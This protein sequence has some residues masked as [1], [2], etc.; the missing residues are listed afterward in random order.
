[1]E[2]GFRIA[3]DVVLSRGQSHEFARKPA[4]GQGNLDF[5]ESHPRESS[6]HDGKKPGEFAPKTAGPSQKD[7]PLMNRDTFYVRVR[8][9]PTKNICEGPFP[10]RD[11]AWLHEYTNSLLI[12]HES[13]HRAGIMV[14][15][16]GAHASIMRG[17]LLA[18]DIEN[19]DELGIEFAVNPVSELKNPE[20]FYD[21]L[22]KD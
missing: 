12:S 8:V 22:G 13:D 11:A 7:K 1:M 5:E 2:D 20:R 3:M 4:A 19:S 18:E 21:L 10:S 15:K 14:R 17:D 16:D 9:S 6:S